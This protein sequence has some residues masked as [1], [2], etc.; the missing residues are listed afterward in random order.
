MRATLA[1]NGLIINNYGNMRN[2]NKTII[3]IPKPR[4]DH[5]L[6]LFHKRWLLFKNFTGLQKLL[7]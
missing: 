1:S 6:F 2:T 4:A 5:Y 7:K 3:H